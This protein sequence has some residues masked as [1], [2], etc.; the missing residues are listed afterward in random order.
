MRRLLPA[1]VALLAV[2]VVAG[3][4][5]TGKDAVATGQEFQFVAPGGKTTIMYDPPSSRGAL[6][7]LSGESLLEPGRTIGTDD[8][9]GKV[10]VVNIWGSW[11]GPC[12]AEAPDLEFSLEQTGGQGVDML[13]ID[14][15]D[16]RAAAT[17]FVRDRGLKYQSIFDPPGRTLAALSGYP[18]NTVPST[19]VL[20]RQHRVAAVFLTRVQPSDLVPL[21]MRVA[22]EPQA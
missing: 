21:L 12:R 2:L 5:T 6:P 3:C 11:C 18:R 16:D 4:G 10:L 8:Y 22:A 15:R 20:D 7:T 19:I 17:D 1:L 13:G 14:V 9:K